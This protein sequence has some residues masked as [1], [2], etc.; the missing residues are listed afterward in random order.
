MA[1]WTDALRQLVYNAVM[2]RSYERANT[3]I[4]VHWLADREITRPGGLYGRIT[5]EHFGTGDTDYRNPLLARV[6]YNL[7]F[8]QRFGFGVPRPREALAANG[9]P[10]PEFRFEQTP[11]SVT[12]RSA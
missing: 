2:R 9:D 6:M 11:V 5:P 10:E 12:V 8:A 4:R 7:G 1:A 3:P